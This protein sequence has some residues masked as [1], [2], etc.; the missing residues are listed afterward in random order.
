M[1]YLRRD[2]ERLVSN[3]AILTT[4]ASPTSIETSQE[5]HGGIIHTELIIFFPHFINKYSNTL[6][7]SFF[8]GAGSMATIFLIVNATLGAG[9]LN[10]PQAFDNSG[11]SITA[12]LMQLVFL[13]FI[14]SA[15]IVLAQCS[16]STNSSSMQ[17][18]L[19]GLCGEKSLKLCAITV[20]IYSFGCCITFLIVIG[21]QFDRILAT[22]YGNDFCH[23]W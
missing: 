3:E 6:F 10:F 11:G 8:S 22:F 19:A 15:I 14:T 17:D 4:A 12:I 5:C 9:L 1:Y 2:N 20:V 7:S 21:D 18:T 23:H 16:D 13:I